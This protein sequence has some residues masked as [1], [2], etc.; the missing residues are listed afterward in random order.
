MRRRLYL[1]VLAISA[2]VLLAGCQTMGRFTNWLVS[3]LL[4]SDEDR[5]WESHSQFIDK[6]EHPEEY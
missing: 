5:G 2:L 3:G 4:E 1:Y 6:C